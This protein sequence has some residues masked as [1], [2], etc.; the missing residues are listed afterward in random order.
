[1]LLCDSY[2]FRRGRETSYVHSESCVGA[3]T[4]LRGSVRFELLCH[5]SGPSASAVM[6]EASVKISLRVR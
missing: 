3:G 4:L 1:M 2:H 6:R 5:V